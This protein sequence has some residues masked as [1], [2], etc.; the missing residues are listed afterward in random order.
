MAGHASAFQKADSSGI[1]GV[2][3]ERS[4][5]CRGLH[6]NCNPT[7]PTGRFDRLNNEVVSTDPLK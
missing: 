2:S 1:A 3:L 5:S 4:C 7:F 6:S